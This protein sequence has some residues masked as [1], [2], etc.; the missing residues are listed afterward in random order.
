M[1]QQRTPDPVEIYQAAFRGFRKTLAGVKLEQLNHPT[2]CTKWHVQNLI[3]HNLRVPGFVQGVFNGDPTD[4]TLD[5]SG[6]LP[7]DGPV[8]ALDAA[9]AS[10]LKLVRAPGA[11][12]KSL[13]T[14]FGPLTGGQFLF[15]PF[16]DFLIHTWDLAKATSQD[17]TL[18]SKLVEACY[19]GLLPLGD[20]LSTAPPGEE[21]AF[22]K[23]VP[24]PRNA[25]MQD[26]LIGFS[27][28]RL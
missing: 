21:P 23:P 10:V 14:P 8:A 3:I 13:N 15:F 26:K 28:R 27:G 1:A 25:S 18:D 12:A 6:P 20:S 7:T 2:P 4:T 22:A 24:V 9:V 16:A 19:N 11:L 5:V 17:A